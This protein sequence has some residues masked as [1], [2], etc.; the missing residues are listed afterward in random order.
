MDGG[1]RSCLG[2]HSSSVNRPAPPRHRPSL[3]PDCEPCSRRRAQNSRAQTPVPEGQGPTL[4]AGRALNTLGLAATRKH[5]GGGTGSRAAPLSGSPAFS[6]CELYKGHVWLHRLRS[7]RPGQP[8]R[9]QGGGLTQGLGPAFGMAPATPEGTEGPIS[10]TH[11]SSRLEM[12]RKGS[13]SVKD[14]V[15]SMTTTSPAPVAKNWLQQAH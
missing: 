8:S 2:D 7:T 10:C 1:G 6:C 12:G 11:K 4:L 3:A 13:Q 15:A 5:T 14:H 9:C